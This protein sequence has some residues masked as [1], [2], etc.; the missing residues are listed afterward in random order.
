VNPFASAARL[1][2][3][4]STIRRQVSA[5]LAVK[6]PAKIPLLL[7]EVAQVLVDAQAPAV[8]CH[9]SSTNGAPS[10]AQ[11]ILHAVKGEVAIIGVGG[12]SSGADT[13][14]FLQSGISALQVATAVMNEGPHAFTRLKR[15]LAECLETRR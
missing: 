11:T 12:V 3:V 15:E 13:L 4:I 7:T 9:N 8:V 2:E 5:P 6:F 1:F 14:A 10:Q